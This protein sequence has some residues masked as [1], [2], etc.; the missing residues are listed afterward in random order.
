[1]RFL[2]W[3]RKFT[4]YCSLFL[5]II[6]FSFTL[7][8]V[9]PS[10]PA[11]TILGPNASQEQIVSLEH[12]L[13][14]D[15]SLPSQFLSYTKSLAVLQFG[16]SFV[17][18]RP[19]FQEVGSKLIVSLLLVIISVVIAFTYALVSI[20]PGCHERFFGAIN[21]LL[22]S[23]P[24]FFSGLVVAFILV[25]YLKISIFS[26]NYLSIHGLIYLVPPAL[27]LSFYPMAILSNILMMNMRQCLR[28]GFIRTSRAFAVPELVIYYKYALRNSM[29]PFFAALS[30]QLPMLFTGA[31]IVEIIFSIPGLGF[32]LVKSILERDFPMLEG[33]II[34]NGAIFILTNLFFESMYPIID[35]R[36]VKK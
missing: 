5:G 29:I 4:Y 36:I 10:N 15:R 3:L 12:S 9:I 18:K 22:I 19:V 34:A 8:H 32:L 20:C 27:V 33:I 25:N 2:Y 31:F 21:Q 24:T 28:S 26:G 23:T 16:E 14:L 13:G 6:F 30:N 7:F 11:R 17:D 35:S 1:M